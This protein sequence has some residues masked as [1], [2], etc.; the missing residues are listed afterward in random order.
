MCEQ[1]VG[2]LVVVEEIIEEE[3]CV[4]GM[5]MDCD[6]V[7]GVV[8]CQY[9]VQV[10]CVGDLMSCDVVSV[11]EDDSLL[12]VLV[13]MCGKVV[14]WVLVVVVGDWLVGVIVFDDVFEIVVQ[15]MQVL[16]VVI[17]VVQ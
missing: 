12:D 1:Q 17:F 11:C 16:V 8:V 14:C 3:C 10:V 2:C 15:E 4:V 7:I 5:L 9:D 6:I 13:V